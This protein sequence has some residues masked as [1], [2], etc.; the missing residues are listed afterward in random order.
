MVRPPTAAITNYSNDLTFCVREPR[1][2]PQMVIFSEGRGHISE[3]PLKHT[4]MTQPEN[5]DIRDGLISKADD[6]EIEKDNPPTDLSAK[7]GLS[8][9]F[10]CH[11]LFVFISLAIAYAMSLF[12]RNCPSI[13]AADMA[14]S[15]GVEKS[16]IGIFT[17]IYF[18]SYAIVQPFT[19]LLADSWEPAYLIGISQVTGAIGTI[20]CGLSSSL[21]FGCFGRF[22]VGLGCGPTYVAVTRCLV[23]WFSLKKYGIVLGI[24]EAIGDCGYLFAQ[25][26]LAWLAGLIGWRWAF[27]G[28]GIL[29]GVLGILD[30]FL[31]RGSPTHYGYPEMNEGMDELNKND[32]TWKEKLK[33]MRVYFLSV[34]KRFDLWMCITFSILTLGAFYDINGMWGA[35][36]LIDVYGMTTQKS[37]NTMMAITIG[38]G[39]G[40]MA[41]PTLSH[42]LKTRKWVLFASCCSSCACCLAFA[43][44][45]NKMPYAVIVAVLAWYALFGAVFSV[46]YALALEYFSPVVAGT[47]AGVMNVF[48]FIVSAVYQSISSAVVSKFGYQEGST[49]K[50]TIEGYKWGVWVLTSISYGLGAIVAVCL[51]N[52]KPLEALKTEEQDGIDELEDEEEK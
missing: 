34:V 7:S 24:F 44:T 8:R 23:N 40:S 38:S 37:G 51:R 28:L 2:K 4:F 30:F 45:S 50:Y 10:Q 9:K 21:E 5:R 12:M 33:K 47:A 16:K 20:V 31:V 46:L 6:M 43:L 11:R 49:E 14:E 52:P 18:Y 3:S 27:I 15:Y 19:G 41:M 25:G 48:T 29:S 39:L 42:F 32:V 35:P 17:S 36:F 26:P 1:T 13:V 22:L